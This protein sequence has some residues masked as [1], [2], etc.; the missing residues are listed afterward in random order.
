MFTAAQSRIDTNLAIVCLSKLPTPLPGNTDRFVSFFRHTGF[1]QKQTT[2][3]A[4]TKK[5]VG[6]MSNLF[7]HPLIVPGRVGQKM[8]VNLVVG[9]WNG[10]GHSLHIFFGCLN[11]TLQILAGNGIHIS[12]T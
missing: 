2:I 10:F 5:R 8:L 9:I 1:V 6:I 3:V 11:Q 12:C 7:D 4:A